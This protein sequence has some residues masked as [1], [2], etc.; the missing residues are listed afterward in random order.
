MNFSLLLLVCKFRFECYGSLPLKWKKSKKCKLYIKDKF[1]VLLLVFFAT[2][3]S[4]FFLDNDI[5]F[6]CLRIKS[7]WGK[8]LIV[9]VRFCKNGVLLKLGYKSKWLAIYNP[10][11]AQESRGRGAIGGYRN[12]VKS[13]LKG[14]V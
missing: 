11:R 5:M 7:V 2:L 4:S 6:V 8:N 14:Q 12:Q 1:S 9:E 10:W 3:N 13:P